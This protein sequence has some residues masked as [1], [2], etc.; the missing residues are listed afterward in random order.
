MCP[1]CRKLCDTWM[2]DTK[3]A[4][5]EDRG[6]QQQPTSKT[7]APPATRY[8]FDVPHWWHCFFL[9][10]RRVCPNFQM[11]PSML[12]RI[13]N[14]RRTHRKGDERCFKCQVSSCISED[15]TY[16]VFSDSGRSKSSSV[17]SHKGQCQQRP[18]RPLLPRPPPQAMAR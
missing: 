2:R 15:V 18:K 4:S 11:P 14:A 10:P 1:C 12:A 13:S 7:P 6:K 16:I 3:I 8:D 5:A 9:H 17:Q